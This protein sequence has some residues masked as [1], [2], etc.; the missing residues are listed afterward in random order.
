M[1]SARID[2]IWAVIPVNAFVI[3]K[4]R[5][6]LEGEARVAAN[7]GFLDHV[8]TVVASVLDVGNIVV[9]SRDEDA[10]AMAR[11]EG[12]RTVLEGAESDL[13]DALTAGARFAG[14]RG[15]LGVLSIFTDLPDLAA[16][17]LNAMIAAFTGDNLVIAPDE[18]GSGSNALLMVPNALPY[19]HGPNSLWRHLEAAREAHAPFAIVRRPGLMR[20][21]DTP[22]QYAE[23]ASRNGERAHQR[24]TGAA[25]LA[26]RRNPDP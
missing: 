1:N 24:S 14:E 4:S 22:A 2:A 13:N 3:G 7:R 19:R 5:L 26:R 18:Q 9:I 25:G 21:I 6:G 11:R 15:A 8:L 12:A 23:I 16:A 17:D 10:L 20:D